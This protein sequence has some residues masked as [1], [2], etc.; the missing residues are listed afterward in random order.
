MALPD[1]DTARLATTET[2]LAEPARVLVLGGVSV[3]ADLAVGPRGPLHQ[4]SGACR[5]L[6]LRS[7]GGTA[8]AAAG[9]GRLSGGRAW[10]RG[11][12]VSARPSATLLTLA[13]NAS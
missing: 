13:G 10:P 11:R 2:A 9:A 6:R 5:R 1:I 7:R 4:R 8:Y 12:P 3:E